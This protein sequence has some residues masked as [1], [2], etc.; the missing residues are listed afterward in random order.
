MGLLQVQ[1]L[2]QFLNWTETLD[3]VYY[4]TATQVMGM[5]LWINSLH[6]SSL[7]KLQ[8]IY[9]VRYVTTA[10][11]MRV[12]PYLERVY[13]FYH[14]FYTFPLPNIDSRQY[15]WF[16]FDRENN[17]IYLIMLGAAVDDGTHSSLRDQ[18][19]RAL[20]L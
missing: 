20:A 5:K 15:A 7:I 16:P 4:V 1:G 12:K 10:Q 3:D 9:Y 13:I 19:V 6:S 14:F 18:E 11:V 8:G 17:D 2:H